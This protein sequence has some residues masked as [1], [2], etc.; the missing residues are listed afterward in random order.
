MATTHY[1]CTGGCLTVRYSP[2]KCLTPGCPRHR[3][4]LTE[5]NCEDDAHGD[6]PH[7]N[8]PSYKKIPTP[9]QKLAAKTVKTKKV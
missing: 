2:N 8:D 9:P 1:V 7:R 4:P 5:C 3:N 6:L